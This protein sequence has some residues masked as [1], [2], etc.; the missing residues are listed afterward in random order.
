MA[1]ASTHD[2]THKQEVSRITVYGHYVQHKALPSVIWV[3][4]DSQDSAAMMDVDEGLLSGN[5]VFYGTSQP[6]SS[7]DFV[8]F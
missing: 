7:D 4:G 3:C 8:H 2:F 5:R 6:D 1:A